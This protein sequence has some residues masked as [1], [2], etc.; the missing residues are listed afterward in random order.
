MRSFSSKTSCAWTDYDAIR[1]AIATFLRSFDGSE[2]AGSVKVVTEAEALK[3]VPEFMRTPTLAPTDDE[4][5]Q[6]GTDL[7]IMLA[8]GF[9]DRA[10]AQGGSH[11]APSLRYAIR[12]IGRRKPRVIDEGRGALIDYRK[13]GAYVMHVKGSVMDLLPFLVSHLLTRKNMVTVHQCGIPMCER[14]FV[15]PTNSQGRDQL[16]IAPKRAVTRRM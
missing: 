5:D 2:D 12:G 7:R 8:D 14:F 10:N 13:P 11:A 16:C 6:L 1:R 15:A 4:L 9:A 3:D